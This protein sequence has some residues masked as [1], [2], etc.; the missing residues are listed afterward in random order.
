[1]SR[2]TTVFRSHPVLV[3]AMFLSLPGAPALGQQPKKVDVSTSGQ[4]HA[5]P[6]KGTIGPVVV[7]ELYQG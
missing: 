6:W 7:T 1:M 5:G 3:L 4:R 2:F